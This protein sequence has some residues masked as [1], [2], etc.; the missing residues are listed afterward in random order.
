MILIK[1][2]FSWNTWSLWPNPS[3][4]KQAI[5]SWSCDR[6]WQ[7]RNLIG[8]VWTKRTV[9]LFTYLFPEWQSARIMCVSLW[10]VKDTSDTGVC[11]S[12][13]ACV[14]LPVRRTQSGRWKLT[15]V[16]ENANNLLCHLAAFRRGSWRTFT[17]SLLCLENYRCTRDD[18]VVRCHSYTVDSGHN[19]E[20]FV[21]FPT[22]LVLRERLTWTFS[23]LD[24]RVPSEN[25]LLDKLIDKLTPFNPLTPADTFAWAYFGVGGRE[26]S[27]THGCFLLLIAASH[28]DKEPNVF[29]RA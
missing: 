22:T 7:L 14:L 27:G 2:E 23:S 25:P 6:V 29:C 28:Q 8:S 10:R 3:A 26:L 16:N 20:A 19:M 18:A 15:D 5:K 12:T 24:I 21:M 4:F 17:K 9:S 11:T 13:T 1:G